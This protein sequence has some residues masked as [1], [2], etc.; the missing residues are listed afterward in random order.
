MSSSPAYLLLGNIILWCSLLV[1]AWLGIP[2]VE[3]VNDINVFADIGKQVAL[4]SYGADMPL[5]SEYPPLASFVFSIFYLLS[6]LFDVSFSRVWLWGLFSLMSLGSLYVFR[7]YGAYCSFLFLSGLVV[8]GFF[9]TSD[10]LFARY[11]ILIGICFFVD[12]RG[13]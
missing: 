5:L 8:A 12:L 9:Y 3:S 2:A 1:L 13:I 11:D 4:I 10:M 6:L 7:T